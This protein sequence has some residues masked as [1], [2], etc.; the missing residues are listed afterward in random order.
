MKEEE[1]K[2]E[3]TFLAEVIYRTSDLS[4]LAKWPLLLLALVCSCGAAIIWYAKADYVWVKR[5]G[6]IAYL[7]RFIGFMQILFLVLKIV[8]VV[9]LAIMAASLALYMYLFFK[10]C[11]SKVLNETV[12]VLLSNSFFFAVSLV[13]VFLAASA[14]H[15]SASAMA[16]ATSTKIQCMQNLEKLGRALVY[17]AVDTYHHYPPAEHWCDK[18][19][20][21]AGLA[22]KDFMCPAG[23]GPECGYA[24]NPHAEPI[25][26]YEDFESWLQSIYHEDPNRKDVDFKT[27]FYWLKRFPRVNKQ[28]L[29][30]V[31]L[32]FEAEGGW[33]QFGGPEILTTK[34]HKG[35]GCH[36]LFNNGSVKFVE[37]QEFEKLKWRVQEPNTIE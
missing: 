24:L 33:N 3:Q 5:A 31:V 12:S 28:Q 22:K 34:N 25:S 17:Y 18:L 36:V 32:L 13:F 1:P 26:R 21:Y 11:T 10:R 6:E 23:E 8:L 19:K 9:C 27:Y 30:D 20:E 35:K 37:P 15:K 7:M 14:Y 29:R 16:V 2:L 4:Q